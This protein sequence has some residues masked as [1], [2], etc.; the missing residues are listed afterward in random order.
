MTNLYQIHFREESLTRTRFSGEKFNLG[1]KCKLQYV[2][3]RV[4]TFVW[5]SHSKIFT[6]GEGEV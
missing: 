6:H 1:V 3:I 2:M 5:S 4:R